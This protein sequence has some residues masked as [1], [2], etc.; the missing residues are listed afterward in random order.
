MEWVTKQTICR[1]GSKRRQYSQHNL[2]RQMEVEGAYEENKPWVNVMEAK[3]GPIGEDCLSNSFP[4]L[5]SLAADRD[6]TVDMGDWEDEAWVWQFEWQDTKRQGTSHGRKT[7]SEVTRVKIKEDIADSWIWNFSK[8][9]VYEV[10]CWGFPAKAN[11]IRCGMLEVKME[12]SGLARNEDIFANRIASKGRIFD[13]IHAMAFSWVITM[14]GR[15]KIN[16]HH[17]VSSPMKAIVESPSPSFLFLLGVVC[18]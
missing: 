10:L 15:N 5:H 16:W 2:V 17:G 7:N 1:L 4:T 6:Y 12:I 14:F 9:R 3:Y 11:I 8:R 18:N 13:P